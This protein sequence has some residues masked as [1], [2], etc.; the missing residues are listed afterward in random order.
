[1]KT[2]KHKYG[3][4]ITAIRHYLRLTQA[5]LG[6]KLG[7]NA[8]TISNYETGY[9]IPGVDVWDKIKAMAPEMFNSK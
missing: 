5:Q 6:D 2:Q 1:M 4:Q 7:L 3:R 9:T 8:K